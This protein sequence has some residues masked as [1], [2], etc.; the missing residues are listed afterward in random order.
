MTEV[1]LYFITFD[2]GSAAGGGSG[3]AMLS[4]GARRCA[5]LYVAAAGLKLL[6][7]PAYRSTDFEVHRNWMAITSSLPLREW[8]LD[9]TS[10]WTL[11]Y[12]PLFAWF[13]RLLSLGA[14]L[15]EPAMLVVSAAP[16]ESAATVAYQ[17]VTV[18]FTDVV[19]LLGVWAQATAA[20]RW[21]EGPQVLPSL[22][23]VALAFLDAGLLLVDHIHFQVRPLR[24][25]PVL[26]ITSGCVV[27]LLLYVVP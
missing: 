14:M 22:P 3:V 20:K 7:L 1:L 5:L 9:K 26:H 19:L 13:E 15:V 11:D 21:A 2:G 8:Y 16:Y 27:L 25:C 4:A 10:Q 24:E 18:I 12:P 23:L 17:R 6:L